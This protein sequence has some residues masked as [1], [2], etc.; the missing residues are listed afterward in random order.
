MKKEDIKKVVLIDQ[1]LTDIKRE[2]D[3]LENCKGE[4]FLVKIKWCGNTE[5]ELNLDS[6]IDE[7]IKL[8]Q[9]ERMN[10]EKEL[11]KLLK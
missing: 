5:M 2:I 11:D 4:L 1:Q 8:K 10:L 7:N 9:T 6:I 3:K